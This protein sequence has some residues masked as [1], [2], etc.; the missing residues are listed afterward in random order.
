MIQGEAQQTASG[1]TPH[2][3]GPCPVDRDE[4][5]GSEGPYTCI[6]CCAAT[7]ND[8]DVC[9]DCENDA[10]WREIADELAAA[11][12]L[13][14]AWDGSDQKGSLIDRLQAYRRL[15][16]ASRLALTTYNQ[17]KERGE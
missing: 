16:D 7:W 17:A 6:K 5:Q 8:C 15:A 13:I 9:D 11:L 14:E 1:W 4:Q 3:G 2:D 10:N 12:E